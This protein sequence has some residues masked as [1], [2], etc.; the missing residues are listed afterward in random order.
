MIHVK[1]YSIFWMWIIINS[2]E[3][4]FNPF[5]IFFKNI[6]FYILTKNIEYFWMGQWPPLLEKAFLILSCPT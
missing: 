5:N 6:K 1:L 4:I 2:L 3:V